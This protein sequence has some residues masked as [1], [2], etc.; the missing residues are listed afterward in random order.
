MRANEQDKGDLP[1]PPSLPPLAQRHDV[2]GHHPLALSVGLGF[3]E[4]WGE[5]SGV[6]V[7]A[8]GLASQLGLGFQLDAGLARG[9]REVGVP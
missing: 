6:G 9:G 1:H 4:S 5:K 2:P 3:S 8:G 7:G